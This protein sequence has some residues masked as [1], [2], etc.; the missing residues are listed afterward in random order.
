MNILVTGGAGFIGGNFV[1]YMRRKHPDCRIVCID[2]LTYASNIDTLKGMDSNKFSFIRADISDRFTVYEVFEAEKFDIAVNFAAESHVDRSI[3]HP[4]VFSRTNIIGAQAVMDACL[5][6][7]VPRFHQ[8]STDEV[9]GDLPLERKD[10][11]FDENSPLRPSSP[12]SATKAAADLL[13]LA[14]VRTY[15]LYA[16]ISR[17]SNNYGPYQHT[18]KLIPLAISRALAGKKITVYGDGTNVRDW[19]YVEDHCSAID[20]IISSAG[21]GEIY[22]VGGNNELQNIS[23]VR[24]VLRALNASDE[25]VE[26]VPDRPGHDIRYSVNSTKMREELGWRP[27]FGFQKGIEMTVKW[28]IDNPWWWSGQ[29]AAL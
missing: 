21:P 3:E 24:E 25:L 10:L 15:G 1:K 23:V 20:A 16:T 9:Y 17:C 14:Y 19:L 4:D 22:N 13:A 28:Y 7:G 11:S 26:Y 29:G 6:Y 8:V 18:E 5:K 12:Y 2:A 27:A